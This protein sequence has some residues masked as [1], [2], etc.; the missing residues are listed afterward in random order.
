MFSK[1]LQSSF[2]ANSLRIIIYTTKNTRTLRE[3][4]CTAAAAGSPASNRRCR[5][6]AY[7]K[8]AAGTDCTCR[9][10]FA[11]CRPRTQ[12]PGWVR[13]RW[14]TRRPV[15]A[16]RAAPDTNGMRWRSRERNLMVAPNPMLVYDLCGARPI[17]GPVGGG[18]ALRLTYSPNIVCKT[19][20]MKSIFFRPNLSDRYPLRMPPVATPARKNIS[21]TFFM[22]LLSHTKSHSEVHVRP[23]PSVELYSQAVHLSSSRPS[24]CVVFQT[25]FCELCAREIHRFT[26]KFWG[27]ILKMEF[28]LEEYIQNT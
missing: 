10:S 27:T 1:V 18:G 24:W 6:S 12:W 3:F 16:G 7:R 17:L 4:R 15:P 22:F 13:N 9:R 28:R 8:R 23:R 21:A 2:Q 11:T 26:S 14:R 25:A 20:E 19:T 5:R